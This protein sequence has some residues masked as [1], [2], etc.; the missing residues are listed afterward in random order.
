MIKID[1]DV[2]WD[3][4]AD[5]GAHNLV[6]GQDV[7]QFF[8]DDIGRPVKAQVIMAEGPGGGNPYVSFEFIDEDHAWEW[9]SNSY[10]PGDPDAASE[11]EEYT[12]R[13]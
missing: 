4:F 12:S 7:T 3:H 8:F 9:F 10:M 5:Q 6:D 11:F 13:S 2:S 1:A